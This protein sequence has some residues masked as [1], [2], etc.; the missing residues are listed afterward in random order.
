MRALP[1]WPSIFSQIVLNH[2][3]REDG[4]G[5]RRKWSGV[6][7]YL[8][9]WEQNGF[10][11]DLGVGWENMPETGLVF[12][13]NFIYSWL[14]R[15]GQGTYYLSQSSMTH[16]LQPLTLAGSILYI[17]WGLGATQNK[18]AADDIFVS[19]TNCIWVNQSFFPHIY[20]FS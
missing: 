2:W 13:S 20:W 8:G 10:R 12:S 6:K 18:A 11:E 7:E 14:Q 19:E 9:K 3:L 15:E 17:M 5:K 1:G 4:G 16:V